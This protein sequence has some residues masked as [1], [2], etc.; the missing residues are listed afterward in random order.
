MR[1]RLIVLLA[2][3][4]VGSVAVAQNP[5]KPKRKDE[6]GVKQA[7]KTEKSDSAKK[8]EKLRTTHFF[9]TELTPVTMSLT[10]NYKKLRGDRDA[11]TSPWR[12]ATLTVTDATG[13]DTIPVRVRTRGIWRLNHCDMPPIRLK[14]AN[15]TIKS[16]MLK[17]LDEPKLISYCK[18]FDDYEQYVLSE[19]QVNRVYNL[20][21]PY[22]HKVRLVRMTYIDSVNNKPIATHSA[23][24]EEEPDVMAG[25]IKG[26]ILKQKGA[27]PDDVE[28]Y[29]SAMFGLFNYMIGNTD[30]AI[31][32]LHNAE[33]VSRDNGDLIAVTYDFDFSGAVNTRYSSPDPR[34]GIKSVRDRLFRGYCVPDSVFNKTADIFKAKKDSIYALYHDAIGQM[35][36]PHVVDETLKYY[37]AFYDILN[38]QREFKG[39]VIDAC[40]GRR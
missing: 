35:Q 5:P 12:A 26:L 25:R 2:L 6:T 14:F 29:Q 3:F 8:A 11:T 39:N 15:A 20:L 10:F 16:T 7:G 36:N 32:V 22:S 27:G 9:D 34:L 19:Y 31:S 21:T 33:L 37:D 40:L 28:P 38:N 18:D 30:F 24:I 13:A 23:I 1:S 4:A 17:G